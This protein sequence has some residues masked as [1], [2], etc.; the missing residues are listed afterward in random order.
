L[1]SRDE[2]RWTL[3]K[4]DKPF[5][6]NCAAGPAIQGISLLQKEE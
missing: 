1:P 4:S 6:L 3:Q 5:L 2:Y